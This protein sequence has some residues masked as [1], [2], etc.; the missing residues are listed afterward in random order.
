VE[1]MGT[2]YLYADE[3]CHT[4]NSD[5][6][7]MSLVTVFCKGIHRKLINQK[8]KSIMQ[9][10]KINPDSEL[11]WTKVS[12]SNVE[13]YIEIIDFLA[14]VSRYG[15]LGIRAI[16]TKDKNNIQTDYNEWYHK[17]Y[18]LLFKKIIDDFSNIFDSFH[19]LIDYKDSQSHQEIPRI[20]RFLENYTHGWERL[21]TTTANSKEH[22]LIQIADVIAGSITY[23]HRGLRTSDA[24]MRLIRHI[25]N[26]FDV[27]YSHSSPL[28]RIDFNF[29]IWGIK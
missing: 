20:G 27:S 16:F 6:N 2:L 19:V 14:L 5:S 23:Y 15:D 29:F 22:T 25:F 17:M 7:S 1:I 8:V 10:H 28:S 12:P 3:S 24:K 4:Q 21:I 13:M 26:K 9:K 11:K 18:Y